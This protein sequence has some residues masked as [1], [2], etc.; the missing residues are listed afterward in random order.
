MRYRANLLLVILAAAQRPPVSCL[1]CSESSD[2]QQ[3]ES[4]RQ[5]FCLSCIFFS[6]PC[7]AEGI[8][9]K[10]KNLFLLLI[11]NHSENKPGFAEPTAQSEG[12]ESW[13][14]EESIQVVSGCSNV[15]SLG[16]PIFCSYINY[17]IEHLFFFNH[18]YFF[19][20]LRE[21]VGR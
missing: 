21:K 5:K 3:A 14:D 17:A 19:F 18:Y 6:I 12:W 4:T 20:S 9:K 8:K 10:N 11:V 13:N 15:S 7:S 2:P 1:C 16:I